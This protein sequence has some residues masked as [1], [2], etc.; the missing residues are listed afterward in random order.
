[1]RP[2]RFFRSFHGL[3]FWSTVVLFGGASARSEP[4]RQAEVV[5]GYPERPW[6]VFSTDLSSDVDDAAAFGF[7]FEALQRGRGRLAACVTDSPVPAAAPAARA[8]LDAWGFR[9]VPLGAYQGDSGDSRD[10]PYARDVADA[11]GQQGR[12]RED[13][14]SDVAVLR[15]VYARAPD[16]SIVFIAVGFLNSLEGLMRS[17]P[18]EVSPL[19]G[20]ALF[21][22]KTALV[23]SVGANFTGNPRGETRWNWRHAHQ[24]A[25]YVINH[26]TRPFYWLPANELDQIGFPQGHPRRG[27]PH[28]V[29]GPEGLG[30]DA[31]TNPIQLAFELSRQRQPG[32]LADGLRRK[33]FDPAAVR[34]ATDADGELF[35]FHHRG[36]WVEIREGRVQVDPAREGPFSI[37]ELRMPT[38]GNQARDYLD[39]ILARLA[40]PLKL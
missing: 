33:A 18:D 5:P 15:R 30:W 19:D 7:L 17:A 13:F 37:L 14:E 2:R 6:F 39:A 34:F 1:M 10:G 20:L 16:H 21:E 31:A 29:T 11:F 26:M 8:I 3:L 12:T 24:A 9:S 25:E 22:R 35:G 4:L 36:V 23:V 40:P 32:L 38:A 28:A 27:A